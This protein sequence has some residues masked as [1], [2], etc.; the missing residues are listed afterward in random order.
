METNALIQSENFLESLNENIIIE[1]GRMARVFNEELGAGKH[2]IVVVVVVVVILDNILDILVTNVNSNINT[3]IS[4]DN[5]T[6][7]INDLS[8]GSELDI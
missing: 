3:T 7:E 6:M 2:G 8:F 5:V 4:F 1:I